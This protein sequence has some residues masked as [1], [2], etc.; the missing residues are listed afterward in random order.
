[1]TDRS[2]HLTVHG[3]IIGPSGRDEQAASALV[4]AGALVAIA[5]G[6]VEIIERDEVVR[7]I[8]DRR[9]AATIPETKLAT[10]FER[11]ARR[12]EQVDF[13][14]FVIEAL[15]PVPTLSLSRNLVELAGRV[16]RADQ[17]VH[18]CELQAIKL[19]RLIT[20]SLPSIKLVTPSGSPSN[21]LYS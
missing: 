20:M 11:R 18:R 2:T 3:E 1:M 7:Y 21:K 13:A 14:Q 12:L 19:I 9:L 15:R 16:A 10:L 5:D 17:R 8:S 4:T 6:Y